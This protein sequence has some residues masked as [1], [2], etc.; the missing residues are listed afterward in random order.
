MLS[1]LQAE[2][3]LAGLNDAAVAAGRVDQFDA[4]RHLEGLESAARGAGR[5]AP[6]R[7]SAGQLAGM[8]IGLV[9]VPAN[10]VSE[11]AEK[12]LSDG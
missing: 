4:A 3:R 11:P 5:S 12:A 8:G 2:E 6:A 9:S 10:D 1:R 7:A